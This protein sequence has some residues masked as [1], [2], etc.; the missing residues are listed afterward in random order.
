[1]AAAQATVNLARLDA[2]F[3]GV[4]T[5]VESKPGDQVSPG[6]PAF[7][8]DDNSRFLV[9]VQVS[10]VDINRIS[11]GQDVIL[12]FDAIL[13]KEYRGV[14]TEVALVGSTNQGVV[15]FVVSVELIDPDESVKPGMTAA[16]NIVANQLND[17]LLVPNRAVRILEGERVVYVMID[18][19]PEPVMIVLGSSSE[20]VS[21]VI[22]GD[23]SVGDLIILN[24]PTVFGHNGP[25]G[26]MGG[27]P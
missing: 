3:A 21:E 5:S 2:P 12:T 24:P 13:D 15:D 27:G 4:V 19:K 25:P 11:E 26:F 9:D 6:I 7:R 1:V 22:E 17:V 20:T 10:E 14:V 16:V 23:L 8:L 18:G